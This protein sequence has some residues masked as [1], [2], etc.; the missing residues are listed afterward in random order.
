[1]LIV[2]QPCFFFFVRSCAMMKAAQRALLPRVWSMVWRG[3]RT[4]TIKNAKWSEEKGQA[5][6]RIQDLSAL[7]KPGVVVYKIKKEV[8]HAGQNKASLVL[9]QAERQ[10]GHLDGDR[11]KSCNSLVEPGDC[12]MAVSHDKYDMLWKAAFRLFD[13]SCLFRL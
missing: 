12:L 3:W 10:V 5:K 13:Y 9:S 1:M 7:G 4:S 11:S 8:N 6:K 2:G